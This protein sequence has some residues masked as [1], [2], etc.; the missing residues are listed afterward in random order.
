MTDNF[1]NLLD[2]RKKQIIVQLKENYEQSIF[3]GNQ[4][5]EA[6]KKEKI[7]IITSLPWILLFAGYSNSV[8]L[9]RKGS[10]NHYIS[11]PVD[12]DTKPRT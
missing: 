7:K 8:P 3:Y 12:P 5:I 9:F 4:V 2:S 6:L 1:K 10:Y 11:G